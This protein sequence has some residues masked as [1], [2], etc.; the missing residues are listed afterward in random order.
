MLGYTSRPAFTVTTGLALVLN[1]KKEREREK[2]EKERRKRKK[3]QEIL[4]KN[5]LIKILIHHR[6]SSSPSLPAIT[7]IV[8][9]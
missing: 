5:R 7:T 1:L 4:F 9:T 8:L 2:K 6:C 3:E